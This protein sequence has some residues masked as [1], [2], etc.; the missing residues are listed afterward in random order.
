MSGPDIVA[1]VPMK[2]LGLGK[3]RLAGALSP[4]ER[5]ALN[6]ALLERVVSA[7]IDAL[8][9]GVRVVG[10][11]ET[12]ARNVREMGGRWLPD[13]GADLNGTLAAA[14][15]SAHDDGLASLYLPADL[16]FLT[17]ADIEGIAGE[18]EQGT[19]HTLAPAR[20]DGGTNAILT[21]V[22]SPFRPA[23]GVDSFRGHEA[24]ALELG[25]PLAIYD[26]PGIGYDLDTA[27]DLEAY[28]QMQP[29]LSLRLTGGTLAGRGRDGLPE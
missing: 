26:S 4:R 15:R 28:E 19:V 17:A 11:D 6:L 10:G 2:P 21:P 29:G 13:G 7:A 27:S 1:I 20:R 12:V 14:F 3:S 23:L 25:V 5:E 9:A 16:P 24:M 8:P 22:G 18:S